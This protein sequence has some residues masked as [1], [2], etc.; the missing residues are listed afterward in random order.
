[1]KDDNLAELN[2]LLKDPIRQNILLKLR[3]YDRLSFEDLMEKLDLDEQQELH[4]QLNVLRD[5]VTEVEDTF[6]LTEQGVSKRPGGQYI[7]T[8]KGID[9]VNEL[10]CF[11][12]IKSEKYREKINEKYHSRQSLRR[13]KLFYVLAGVGGGYAISFFGAVFF[14]V[15]SIF[16]FHG[17][18]FFIPDGWPFYLTVLVFAPVLGGFVGYWMGAKKNFERPEPEWNYD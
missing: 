15:L 4:S 6:L 8:E 11:P 1:M 17:P 3:R 7:L 14:T 2:N 9:A 16:V 13:R 10:V 12:E 18:T 5:L